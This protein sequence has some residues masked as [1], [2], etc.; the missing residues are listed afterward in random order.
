MARLYYDIQFNGMLSRTWHDIINQVYFNGKNIQT[1][2][3]GCQGI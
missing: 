1:P 2:V 3:S